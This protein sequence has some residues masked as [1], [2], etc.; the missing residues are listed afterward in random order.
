[1]WLRSS[2]LLFRFNNIHL[3]EA[4][5]IIS[6]LHVFTGGRSNSL[7]SPSVCG[8][9]SYCFVSKVNQFGDFVLLFL[10]IF[11]SCSTMY[12]TCNHY[13]VGSI[14]CSTISYYTHIFIKGYGHTT[15]KMGSGQHEFTWS[16]HLGVSFIY[17]HT[18]IHTLANNIFYFEFRRR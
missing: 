18:C 1:M 5:N 13:I 15:S 16:M 3:F 7:L 14:Y 11:V 9:T 10:L 4:I 6:Y 17:I 2:S 12:N 8:R